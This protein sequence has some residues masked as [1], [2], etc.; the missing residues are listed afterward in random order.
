MGMSSYRS[1]MSM[2]GMQMGAGGVPMA[3]MAQP[4]VEGK[5][6]G[7]A[8]DFDAQMAK[9]FEALSTEETQSARIVEVDGQAVENAEK[10][11]TAEDL[12]K[13]VGCTSIRNSLVDRLTEPG[14]SCAHP[15]SHLRRNPW[16]SGKP[17][18]IS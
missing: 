16:R 11:E 12:R 9:A 15:Q 13:Y 8:V 4:L 7:R 6:K 3:G 17:S 18:S 1:P 5:G 2:Y 14:R 10:P